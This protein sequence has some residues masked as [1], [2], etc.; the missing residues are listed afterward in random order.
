M[1][2]EYLHFSYTYLAEL[3][4]PC[5]SSQTFQR[6]RA[7]IIQYDINALILFYTRFTTITIR[8]SVFNIVI[9][10]LVLLKPMLKKAR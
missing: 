10:T 3:Y 1:E 5:R 2:E 9:L 7:P 4:L 8:K 6:I